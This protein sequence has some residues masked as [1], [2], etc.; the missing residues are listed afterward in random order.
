VRLPGQH[1]KK[2]DVATVT[3]RPAAARARTPQPCARPPHRE[4]AAYAAQDQRRE[5][6]P[7][8]RVRRVEATSDRHVVWSSR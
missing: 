7:Q 6:G 3:A 8:E 1:A 2:L 4:I 5:Q